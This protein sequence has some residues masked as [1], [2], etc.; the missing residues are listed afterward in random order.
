MGSHCSM[1]TAYACHHRLMMQDLQRSPQKRCQ[2]SMQ[3][4]ADKTVHDDEADEAHTSGLPQAF[5]KI[6]ARSNRKKLLLQTVNR[7]HRYTLLRCHKEQSLENLLDNRRGVLAVKVLRSLRK[8]L[9]V[10]QRFQFLCFRLLWLQSCSIQRELWLQSCSI[11]RE[12]R[13]G[14]NS[15]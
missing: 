13:P 1:A 2:S 14:S 4:H 15:R 5:N 10:T 12:L 3:V 11:Q 7:W 8:H 6:C 9:E